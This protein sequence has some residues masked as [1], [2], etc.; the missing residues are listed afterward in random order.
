MPGNTDPR[1]PGSTVFSRPLE[2]P[3]VEERI[4][5]RVEGAV[6]SQLGLSGP[7]PADLKMAVEQASKAAAQSAVEIT[8]AKLADDAAR[9]SGR[10]GVLDRFKDKL[11]FAADGMKVIDDSDQ[12]SDVLKKRANLMAKKRAALEE[13]GFSPDEAFQILLADINARG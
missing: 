6:R 4:R 11:Q 5:K 12:V 13:A 7:S 9:E 3:A 2:V 8:V 10:A 1:N